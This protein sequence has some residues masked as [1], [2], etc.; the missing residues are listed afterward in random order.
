[1]ATW[2]VAP[3]GVTSWSATPA[4]RLFW[5]FTATLAVATFPEVSVARTE[6]VCA[7]FASEPVARDELHEVVPCA[8]A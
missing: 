8:A 1:V 4:G 6:I 7:P 3:S 2:I 5:T